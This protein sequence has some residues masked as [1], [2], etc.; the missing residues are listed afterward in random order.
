MASSGSRVEL[1]ESETA[2]SKRIG[3]RFLVAVGL[4][5]F[6]ALLAYLDGGYK[7]PV[8]GEV[9]LLDAFYYASVSVTTTG[10]GDIVPVTDGA[11]LVTT[12]LVTPARV[13]FLILLVGTT[14]EV[15]A[16]STRRSYRV[17]RW[18]ARLKNHI[19]I[20]GF[21]SKGRAAAKTLLARGVDP[22][23]I[24]IIDES[25]E[26]RRRATDMGLAAVSGNATSTDVLR[27]AEIE[28]ADSIIVAPD[29]DDAAVLVTLTARELN[30]QATIASAVR[31][32]ENVHLLRHG[33]ANSV[34]TSSGAAG[35]L[36]GL[37][38]QTPDVVEVLE[39][40]LTVG[41]GLDLL[42][43]PVAPA[44]IGPIEDVHSRDPVLAVVR[45]GVLMRF[46]DDR[47]ST[48][49][50]GDELVYL[51]SHADEDN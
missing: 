22:D 23:Q 42:Q 19:I 3:R 12:L 20:C 18:K 45:D 21:G 30:P 16:E 46:D 24:V 6:V 50:A 49:A 48:L 8:D 39:D 36:L 15:L 27:A 29:R 13:L 7:D 33:G 34:I 2:A 40:L 9:S 26:A 37:A 44:E 14:L 28:T 32:E 41:Q 31:E 38:T 51:R 5:V 1:P 43:R 25:E 11:R 35:R 17:G 10:Y 4:I 47:V